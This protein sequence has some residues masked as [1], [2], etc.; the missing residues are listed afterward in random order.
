MTQNPVLIG[1]VIV[2]AIVLI[3]GGIVALGYNGLVSSEQTVSEKWAQVETQYQRRLDLIPNLVNTV[4]GAGNFEQE[5]LLK[6]S[7]LRTRWQTQTS[8]SE[9]VQTTNELESTLSK[10]LIVAEN[11]PQ[12]TATQSY[13]D[14]QV[15]LEGTENRVAFARG[16]YNSAVR[17]YNTRIKTF[18][19]NMIAG[20]FGFSE[21]KFFE[22]TSGAQNA[23]TVDFG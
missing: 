7:E 9:R 13:R 4:K 16:E 5:T 11:Y 19:E 6:L 8:Q 15:Q 14:L 20:I 10:L 3:A 22:S 21:K 12:L 1:I 17:T 23:P 2:V 18:P